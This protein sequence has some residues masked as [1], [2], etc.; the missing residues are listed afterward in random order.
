MGDFD[1]TIFNT[2]SGNYG[3]MWFAPANHRTQAQANVYT[4]VSAAPRLRILSEINTVIRGGWGMYTSPW[5]VDQYGNAKGAG[6]G[7]SG[8]AQDQT[9]GITP[10]TTLSGPGV[11]YGTT[12]PLPYVNAS[13]S[14]TAYNGQNALNYDPYHTPLTYLYSW[15]LGVQH[16]F[17]HG[18]TSEVCVCRQAWRQHAVQG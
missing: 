11:F 16:E 6:Y 15:S 14:P 1:P 10:V 2:A 9:N 17:S 5:S 13:T 12:T 8:N 7:Q 4:R 3:A 18:I